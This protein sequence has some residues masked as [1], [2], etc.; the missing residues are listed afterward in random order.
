M[1]SAVG[2]KS[3]TDLTRRKAR[4]VLAVATLAIAVASVG[5]L[6]LPP[7]ADR[8]MQQEVA[9]TRLSDLSVVMRP[10]E[11]DATRLAALRKLPNVA[12]VEPRSFFTTRM[13]VGERRAEAI[14]I[15]VR[16]FDRQQV[17]VVTVAS[18]SA[19]TDGAVLTELQNRRQGRY[20]ARVGDVARV[21]ASDGSVRRL[22]IG[23]EGR[24]LS[25][26]QEVIFEGT[27]VLYAT[28][29]TVSALSG[30][31]GFS[32]LAFRL[33]DTRGAAVAS[34]VAAVRRVLATD[35]AFK[36]FTELPGVR[37]AGDW[38]G[39]EDL[40]QF[41]SLLSIVTLLALLSALVL[42]ANTMATLV[43]EQTSEIG[44][45]KAMGGRRRQI[46]AVYL[47][48]AVLLGIL[49]TLAGGLLGVLLAN[50]LVRFFGSEFFAVE[51]GFAVDV[52]I[53][54]ASIAIGVLGPPLATLPAIRRGTRVTVREA[55]EATGSALGGQGTVDRALRR[56]R[57]LPPNAQIGLRSIGRRKRR[58][59]TTAV[60]IGFAVATLLAVL[61][62]GAAAAKSTRAAWDEHGEDI[63][64]WSSSSRPLDAR[65][66]SL[67]RAVP[68]VAEAEPVLKNE[69]ELE[70][71]SA[72][73]W[74]QKQRTM[75]HHRVTDGRWYTATEERTEA[76]VAV[77]E[78][79][80]ARITGAAVG[81]RV[82]V[83]TAN[84]SADLRI[85][86]V[87]ANLQEGG[88]VLFVPITTLRSV[89]GAADGYD[90]SIKT[91]T[92]EHTL[93]DRTTTRV[94]DVLTAHGYQPATEVTYVMKEEE[95]ARNRTLTTTIAVLGFL[96]VAISMMG[97]VSAMTMSVLER[98]REIGILRSVGAR[99]RDVRRIFAA[100]AL[101]L[102]F[103]GWL[104]GVPLGYAL[105]RL[106]VWLVKESLQI[107]IAFVFP[108]W[109][110]PLA[111]AGTLV[112]ALVLVL[113]P[114]RR[115]VR[116]RPGAAL[117]YA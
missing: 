107:E 33:R 21:L 81:D 34:T 85:V 93:I 8:A 66:G 72:F 62:L 69:V 23:G 25:Q 24:N 56:V 98:T 48:T 115:A 1:L 14:V 104:L 39:K 102:A 71:D 75:F 96:I 35:P 112:L 38:P 9:A 2:R 40:G 94:E 20:E 114:L 108:P 73:L 90:Y 67:I 70:G 105:D 10:L 89:I 58:T 109:N 64:V 27:I 43:G 28:P 99:A 6:A 12:A 29:E 63:S 53:L 95:V 16:D 111:L 47:R 86:G 54:L 15:G 7:L 11:L 59:L 74:G 5:I 30:V 83:K 18:G 88:T 26:G 22:R 44:A 79:D 100:E 19:P 46:A 37:A 45:M 32:T 110:V 68:G 97:L 87:A 61:G 113:L 77:I 55:I 91:T 116:L 65:A 117:R 76:R 4:A 41:T 42:I 106:L 80:L 60:Q 51:T 57:F 36:G 101:T 92:A 50:G 13:Y 84:G 31:P 103:L 17:D 49:G 3:V 78:R 82:R 52:P